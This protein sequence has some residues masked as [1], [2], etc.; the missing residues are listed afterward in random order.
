MVI[1]DK[2]CLSKEQSIG[3]MPVGIGVILSVILLLA[4]TPI[5]SLSH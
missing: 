2:V 4:E 5:A 1:L 3:L